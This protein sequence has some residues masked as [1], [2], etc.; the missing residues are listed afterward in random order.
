MHFNTLFLICEDS[1]LDFFIMSLLFSLHAIMK[2]KG[3][4]QDGTIRNDSIKIAI[5]L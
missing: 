1:F 5:V 3:G 4:D 2:V